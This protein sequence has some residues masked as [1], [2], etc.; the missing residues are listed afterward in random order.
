MTKQQFIEELKK[1][2][3]K[4]PYSEVE[5]IIRD[6]EEYIYNAVKAG[7]TEAD[8]VAALGDPKTFAL[9]LSIESKIQE[10]QVAR[11]VKKQLSITW[12]AV[13]AVLALAP[14]NLFFVLGPF[15][16]ISTL[17][18][19]AWIVVA[20]LLIAAVVIFFT[21]L[22][23]AFFVSAGLWASLAAIFF[24][25]G[26]MGLGILGFLAMIFITRFLLLGTMAYLKWNINF[27][28]GRA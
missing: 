12:D 5:D 9:N 15:L 22:T 19:S 14:L 3:G 26:G 4:L 16:V 1:N 8:A 20:A 28:K 24:S 18:F 27:V 10:A 6:Q 11:S 2:L 7:R 17:T 25:A 21:F 23:K 13:I